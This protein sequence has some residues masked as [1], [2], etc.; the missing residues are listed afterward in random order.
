MKKL[1]KILTMVVAVLITAVLFTTCKQFLEDPEEFLGYWSSEVV[2]I[3]FSINKPYQT[4]NDGALCI[5]SATDVI[6]T[7]KLRN[8]KNFTIFTPGS[9]ADAGKVINFPG[10]SPQPVH[11]IHYTLTKTA[12]DTLQ[13]KYKE[14]FLKAHE[15]SNGSIGPEITLISTDGRKF[16]KKFSLNIEANT[17]PPEIGD[18]TIAKTKT[19]GMYVLHFK[20]DNMTA[21]L[22]SALLH[23]DIAYLNVQKEGGTERKIQI[24]AL[25]S[26]FD[27]S[28]GGPVLLQSTE[29]DPLI[30]TIT[31]GNWELYVKTATK[32]TE[33]TLPT[34]YT[35][36]LTDK[37]GLSSAPK[38]AKTLGYIASGGTSTDAWKNLKQAV[39]EASNGT[40][41]TVM[42]EVK[43][44]TDSDN[45][46]TINVTK[47]ITIKG[48]GIDPKLD[49]NTD[50]TGQQHNIFTI[51]NGGELTLK[52]LTLTGGKGSSWG[53]G[54]VLANES[55]TLNMINCNVKDCKVDNASGGAINAEGKKA[56]VHIKGGEIRGNIARDGGGISLSRGAKAVLENCTLTG[57]EAKGLGGAIFATGSSVVMTNCTITGNKAK[58]KGGAI[59]AAKTTSTNTLSSV[60]IEGGVIGG[61]EAEK[62]N[63]TTDTESEGGGIYMGLS[64]SLYLEDSTGSGGQSLQIIG[65]K[66]A[67]GA[68]VYA[69]S[70]AN[71]AMKDST[72][73]DINNDM[74][75]GSD[76]RIIIYGTLSPPSGIA[77]CITPENYRENPPVQVLYEAI[78]VGSPPNYTKFKVTKPYGQ[79]W[80]INS[81]G[82]L[83]RQ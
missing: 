43:A 38:E 61:T 14:S 21:L 2:P 33:S 22:G 3:D 36:W 29:V 67:K 52:N 12:P 48:A 82:Y 51:E 63:K 20:A 72:Q 16:S 79:N 69:E 6:L 5:P 15:W 54:A 28:H 81:R 47:K 10:L 8:P 23:K 46:G 17:P 75:L 78:N 13:L 4:S 34:K 73:I 59:Y 9:A 11:G 71:V 60:T 64:C 41:I 37:K 80:I 55:C 42:G 39:K 19:G 31:S 45:N 77:A 58:Y 24:S 7:I 35:V 49:A 40:V 25:A 76:A 74:Y 53:G 68:G 62:A 26:Q 27:T 57:N 66:A 44:T 65:N 32:L 70:E 30:D 18:I 56:V 83:Q 1:L 50:T